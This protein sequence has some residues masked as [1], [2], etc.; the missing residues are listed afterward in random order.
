MYVGI[1]SSSPSS[2]KNRSQKRCDHNVEGIT[3]NI[4]KKCRTDLK[5]REDL[6]DEIVVDTRKQTGIIAKTVAGSDIAKIRINDDITG[7]F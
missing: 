7:F 3:Y 5:K 4:C 2:C 1:L 6:T